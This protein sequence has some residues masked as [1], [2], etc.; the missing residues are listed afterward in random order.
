MKTCFVWR[1]IER[2]IHSMNIE[3]LFIKV[4]S[5]L[6]EQGKNNTFRLTSILHSSIWEIKIVKMKCQSN[7]KVTF[8]NIRLGKCISSK[9]QQLEKCIS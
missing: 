8:S 1:K 2:Y 5:W 4:F 7:L 9:S 3:Y 6:L